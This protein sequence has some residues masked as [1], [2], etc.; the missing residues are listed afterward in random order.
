[1]GRIIF[2]DGFAPGFVR[3]STPYAT[4]AADVVQKQ[5]KPTTP[6]LTISFEQAYK[7]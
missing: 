6:S 4:R 7:Q 3:V 1:M 5:H 2:V